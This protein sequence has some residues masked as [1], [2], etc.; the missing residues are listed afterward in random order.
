MG[1]IPKGILA[2]ADLDVL[3]SK[4]VRQL[5]NLIGRWALYTAAMLALGLIGAAAV[6]IDAASWGTVLSVMGALLTAALGVEHKL[7]TNAPSIAGPKEQHWPKVVPPPVS[8]K[9]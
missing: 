1:L 3:K 6:F 7:N 8:R 4:E 9:D 2:S 5:I